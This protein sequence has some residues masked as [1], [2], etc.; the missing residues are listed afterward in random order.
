MVSE[1][2]TTPCWDMR[3]ET[4]LA[5]SFMVDDTHCY[6]ARTSIMDTERKIRDRPEPG[7]GQHETSLPRHRPMNGPFCTVLLLLE[8]LSESVY[9][10]K[11]NLPATLGGLSPELWQK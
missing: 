11:G 8:Q 10:S 2:A 3:A 7:C 4:S 6:L 5:N 1:W 9:V